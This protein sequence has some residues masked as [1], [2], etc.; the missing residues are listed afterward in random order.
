MYFY[1]NKKTSKSDV[2]SKIITNESILKKILFIT[3]TCSNE[4]HSK[5]M[6]YS[7]AILK[8]IHNSQMEMI[9][10]GISSSLGNIHFIKYIQIYSYVYPNAA[11]SNY[12]IC[13]EK[14][15]QN[16]LLDVPIRSV[17]LPSKYTSQ[18]Y[19]KLSSDMWIPKKD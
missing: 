9:T 18:L 15:L 16:L 10:S 5:N 13:L 19:I 2:T 4:I 1:L 6:N 7:E 8:F 17:D 14:L 3:R 11:V 12:W